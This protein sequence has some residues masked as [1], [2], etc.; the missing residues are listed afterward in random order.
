MT[1]A[2][3]KSKATAKTPAKAPAKTK[4]KSAKKVISIVTPCYNEV[5]GIRQCYDEV[6]RVF[7]EHLPDYEREHLFC[8]NA[9]TDGTADILR[10]LA[11]EDPDVKVIINAR[12]FGPLRSNFNGIINATGDVVLLFLA[13]DL[14]DPPELLPEFIKKWEEGFEVVYGVRVEREEGALMKFVRSTYYR[15]LSAS[16]NVDLPRNVGD[17][18]LVD[19][20]VVDAMKGFNDTDPF[21]R[22][23]TFECGFNQVGIP[24]TWRARKQGVSK[25]RIFNLIDQGLT[26]LISF[27][28]LPMRAALGIGTAIAALSILFAFINVVLFA[29]GAVDNV[30]RGTTLL[31]TAIFFFAGVQLFFLG[32]LGEYVLAIYNQ[33]RNRPLVIERERVNFQGDKK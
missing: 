29:T 23:M 12:N 16:A 26:G 8:D 27:S 1:K 32:F 13:A 7:E 3:A 14:Q 24:Y 25:N 10:T 9:S 31:I 6:K 19:R 28:S 4:A 22:V 30:P 17:F 5:E 20:K 33:T 2:P 18:Q 21:V 15:V 11:A